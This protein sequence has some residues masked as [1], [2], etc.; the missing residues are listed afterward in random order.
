MVFTHFKEYCNGIFKNTGVNC[1]WIINNSQQVLACLSH[2][3]YIGKAQHFD[4]FD[5]TTLYT[6][7][8]HDSRKVIL[9]Y[10]SR[11]HLKLEVV[12]IC[13]LLIRELHIGV[14]IG[15]QL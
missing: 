6:N 5:F 3:N 2:L 13:P 14:R 1:F 12:N 7:I 15:L 8:P 10:L 11:K 4:S 9:L